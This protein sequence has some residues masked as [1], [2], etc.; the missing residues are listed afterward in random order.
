MTAEQTVKHS[1]MFY[2]SITYNKMSAYNH[3]FATIGNGYEWVDGELVSMDN[4]SY[5][6]DDYD[7]LKLAICHHLESRLSDYE[8]LH[9]RLD[10]VRELLTDYIKGTLEWEAK[11]N[12]MEY[13]FGEHNYVRADKYVERN[14]FKMSDRRHWLLIPPTI[15]SQYTAIAKMPEYVNDD[16][17]AA[18]DEFLSVY[19]RVNVYGTYEWA[20]AQLE[21]GVSVRNKSDGVTLGS[22]E[23]LTVAHE[24]MRYRWELVSQG[25][26]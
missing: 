21:A 24:S 23:D 18:I 12:D 7:M 26:V 25:W 20:K 17:M 11:Y 4:P 14:P 2:P 3:L 8:L 6:K 15:L 19:D 16:W 10:F 9:V 13:Y 1:L 22:M 5:S